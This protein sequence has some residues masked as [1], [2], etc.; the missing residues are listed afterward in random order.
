M[1]FTYLLSGYK[2]TKFRDVFAK[3]VN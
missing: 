1:K 3:N 2:G